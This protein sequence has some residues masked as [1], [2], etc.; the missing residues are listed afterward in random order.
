TGRR[1]G[2]RDGSA[3]RQSPANS[4]HLRKCLGGGRHQGAGSINLVSALCFAPVGG[5][6]GAHQTCRGSWLSRTRRHRRPHWRPQSGN[7]LPSY[8]RGHARMLRLSRPHELCKRASR[9]H[10]YDGIDL[11]GITG[12]GESSNLSLATVKRM[13]DITKMKI[14]L[15]GILTSEDAEL[16]AQNGMD[17]I[18]V[19]NHGGRGED[20]G[21]STI[22]ALPEIIA[23]VN[24]R[25][26]VIVDSGFRRG[27]D[28]VKSLAIGA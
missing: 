22:D 27:T 11:S 19:S 15:K 4:I 3:R 8:A 9:R 28:V 14:V 6:P 17:G 1:G 23:A 5:S 18:I 2:S 16:A 25:M 20:N 10:N 26:T 13:R 24:N 21:R 12:S 7:S